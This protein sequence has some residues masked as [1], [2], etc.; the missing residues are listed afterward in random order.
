MDAP[1]MNTRY[2]GT[3]GNTQ[4][5]KKDNIPELKAIIPFNSMRR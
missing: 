1:L 2:E 5:A 4:G 3:S